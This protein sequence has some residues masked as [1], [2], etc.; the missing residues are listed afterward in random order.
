MLLLVWFFPWKEILSFLRSLKAAKVTS[1]QA[2]F[3]T[4]KASPKARTALLNYFL[5]KSSLI[6]VAICVFP[7][8][9]QFFFK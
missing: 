6:K 2:E 1:T 5:T 4:P 7:S 9:F 3:F 8:N